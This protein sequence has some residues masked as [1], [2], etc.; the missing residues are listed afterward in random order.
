MGG[1]SSSPGGGG[2][3]G[4]VVSAVV[5][6][7]GGVGTVA[8]V[9]GSPRVGTVGLVILVRVGGAAVV[10]GAAVVRTGA[11]GTVGVVL[12]SCSRVGGD[13][14]VSRGGADRLTVFRV[15]VVSIGRVCSTVEA[16]GSG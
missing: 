13:N 8:M 2:R 9:P 1:V 14:V 15:G 4:G 12:A 6:L 16:S 10:E 3:D 11:V 5:V 7:P